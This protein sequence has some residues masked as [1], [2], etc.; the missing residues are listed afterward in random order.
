MT[1]EQ[2]EQIINDVQFELQAR[3]RFLVTLRGSA[4]LLYAT[5]NEP[6]INTGVIELQTTR[7]WWISEHSTETEVVQTILK[8]VLT[9]TEHRTREA[10][11][12]KSKRCFGPHIDVAAH[13]VA[14]DSAD[15][16]EK[17]IKVE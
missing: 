12:Y 2:I 3:Y 5:Y 7:K 17:L 8:C 11:I 13:I 4:M 9:S 6:D 14:A 16:R 15:V 1:V 10:F